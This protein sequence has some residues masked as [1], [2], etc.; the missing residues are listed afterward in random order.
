M[1][2]K[3]ILLVD[4]RDRSSQS[5]VDNATYELSRPIIGTKKCQVL[6]C[7]TYNTLPN[8]V[9]P[10]NTLVV[11]GNAI[12]SRH[13]YHIIDSVECRDTWY[14]SCYSIREFPDDDQYNILC[15]SQFL[16]PGINLRFNANDQ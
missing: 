14:Q 2:G 5:T 12:H 10:S 16:L 7:M 13:P 1:E 9:S 4:S 15:C 11:D 6:F 3:Q 8:V